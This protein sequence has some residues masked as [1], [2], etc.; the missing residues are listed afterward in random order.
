MIGIIETTFLQSTTWKEFSKE[1]AVVFSQ[2]DKSTR[3]IDGK[4]RTEKDIA[5]VLGG[6][7]S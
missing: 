4:G 3:N 7:Q 5:K 1:I 6:F 2:G